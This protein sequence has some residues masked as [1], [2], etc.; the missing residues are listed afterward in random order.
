MLIYLHGRPSCCYEFFFEFIYHF[1]MH[2]HSRVF[3]AYGMMELALSLMPFITFN[4]KMAIFYS[5]F[6]RFVICSAYMG[7]YLAGYL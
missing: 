6:H 5:F 1:Q 2:L 7:N 3:E 4:G